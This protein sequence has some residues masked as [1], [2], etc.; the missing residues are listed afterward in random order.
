MANG[1]FCKV[2][3]EQ[4]I[5]LCQAL[6]HEEMYSYLLFFT[7]LLNSFLFKCLVNLARIKVIMGTIKIKEFDQT[8]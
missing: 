3:L 5:L 7:L 1:T 6:R 8:L 2:K 4:S